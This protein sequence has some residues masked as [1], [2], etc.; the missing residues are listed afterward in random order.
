MFS[1][2]FV[3]CQKEK[4]DFE[5]TKSKFIGEWIEIEPCDSCSTVTFFKDNS[6][7]INNHNSGVTLNANYEILSTAEIKLNRLWEVEE[8]KKTN[9]SN[10]SFISPDTLLIEDFSVVDYG[11]DKYISIKLIKK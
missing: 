3:N 5:E 2:L 8:T 4:E 9:I 11:V 6:L 1:V 10:F 7:S